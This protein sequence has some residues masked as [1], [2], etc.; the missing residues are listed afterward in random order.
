MK[1]HHHFETG[2]TSIRR[3][4]KRRLNDR[5]PEVEKDHGH[6][7][8]DVIHHMEVMDLSNNIGESLGSGRDNATNDTDSGVFPSVAKYPSRLSA[9]SS[10]SLSASVI[11]VDELSASSEDRPTSTVRPNE[12][13]RKKRKSHRETV[14]LNRAFSTSRKGLS[15]VEGVL[16]ASEA[17]MTDCWDD[18]AW[19]LPRKRCQS[20]NGAEQQRSVRSPN[21]HKKISTVEVINTTHPTC[22][23]DPDSVWALQIHNRASVPRVGSTQWHVYNRLRQKSSAN[24]NCSPLPVKP[25]STRHLLYRWLRVRLVAG[26]IRSSLTFLHEILERKYREATVLLRGLQ[27]DSND[28]ERYLLPLIELRDVLADVWCV[29]AHFSIDVG[30]LALDK[31]ESRPKAQT[32]KPT[33]IQRNMPCYSNEHSERYEASPG[34]KDPTLTNNAAYVEFGTSVDLQAPVIADFLQEEGMAVNESFVTVEPEKEEE[35]VINVQPPSTTKGSPQQCEY[36]GAAQY[37]DDEVTEKTESRGEQAPSLARPSEVDIM[38]RNEVGPILES[39]NEDDIIDVLNSPTNQL[40]APQCND[41]VDLTDKTTSSASAMRPNP[42]G[43]YS[44]ET[45]DSSSGSFMAVLTESVS[46]LVTKLGIREPEEFLQRSTK[47]LRE[48]LVEVRLE[49]GSPP[50]KDSQSAGATISASKARIKAW[51][52][53]KNGVK[54]PFRE[55]D[56][57]SNTTRKVKR[58]MDNQRSRKQAGNLHFLQESCDCLEKNQK[59]RVP[60]EITFRDVA[61]HAISILSAARGCPL[62]GNHTLIALNFGRLIVSTSAVE[63]ADGSL[64]PIPLSK[65]ELTSKINAAIGSCWDVIRTCRGISECERRSKLSPTTT[66]QVIEFLAEFE[67]RS[68]KLGNE[69]RVSKRALEFGMKEVLNLPKTLREATKY[70]R[71]VFNDSNTIRALCEEINKWSRLEELVESNSEYRFRLR[72]S[73]EASS[74]ILTDDL[75]LFAPLECHLETLDRVESESGSEGNTLSIGN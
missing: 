43:E 34:E 14:F 53:V 68:P 15:T 1:E 22:R 18:T 74:S 36:Y 29:Y 24:R 73:H 61:E 57:P 75:P 6:V 32:R 25:L 49:Q 60:N 69:K 59:E 38:D 48:E 19:C 21:N 33:I 26:L 63:Y 65:C 12:D 8:S 9:S 3:N 17:D 67:F 46:A 45:N 37:Y 70:E 62:V 23:L 58:G 51:S 72:P 16:T 54:Q 2:T 30:L 20:E 13:S 40:D 5:C 47:S 39:A 52:A 64:V 31:V 27:N 66:Q 55:Y 28:P 44:V 71:T 42:S 50:L 7:A 10:A 41:V 4:R 11:V 56:R 35:I